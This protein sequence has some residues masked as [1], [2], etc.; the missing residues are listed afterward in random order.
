VWEHGSGREGGAAEQ[1]R[2]RGGG[3]CRKNGI[4]GEGGEEVYE[5]RVGGGS[6]YRKLGG[7]MRREKKT[8]KGKA[9]VRRGG[10]REGEWEWWGSGN[11]VFWKGGVGGKREDGWGGVEACYEGGERIGAVGVK[12]GGD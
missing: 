4:E 6:K 10:G 5:R 7:E 11:W 9:G 1:I 2:K 12:E 3:G 8:G